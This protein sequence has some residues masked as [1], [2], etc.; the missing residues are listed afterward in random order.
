M[1]LWLCYELSR[2]AGT[3]SLPLLLLPAAARARCAWLR[4]RLCLH[5]NVMADARAGEIRGC[6]LRG[7]SQQQQRRQQ[8]QQ[9]RC[10]ER[11]RARGWCV[12]GGH[13]HTLTQ[14]PVPA[15]KKLAG[16]AEL[17]TLLT[18]VPVGRW[19]GPFRCLP[20]LALCTQH[21]CTPIGR[22][23]PTPVDLRR[24]VRC[25]A[26]GAWPPSACR[27]S[28]S[29]QSSSVARSLGISSIS[30]IISSRHHARTHAAQEQ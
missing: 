27:C 4:W 6:L 9:E 2:A 15:G 23:L 11:E 1:L 8:Q 16:A 30:S 13:G 28:S 29:R 17:D 3:P 25:A 12:V 5:T 7:G 24:S 18:H 22:E 26:S 10:V 21:P 19:P 14:A 20:L